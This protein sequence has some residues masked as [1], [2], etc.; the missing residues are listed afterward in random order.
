M[1]SSPKV[2]RGR[3]SLNSI[4]PPREFLARDGFPIATGAEISIRDPYT[5]EKFA[6]RFA[7]I[8]ATDEI[9][10]ATY[11]MMCRYLATKSLSYAFTAVDLFRNLIQ[12][13][14][15]VVGN[16][17]GSVDLAILEGWRHRLIHISPHPLKINDLLE[18]AC[19]RR[20]AIIQRSTTRSAL[21][22]GV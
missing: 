22:Q 19:E 17:V 11:R 1:S 21:F 12:S 18:P 4:C 5:N 14:F 8:H 20:T 2:R 6:F 3:A 13:A 15:D 9:I 10:A 16:L 7:D